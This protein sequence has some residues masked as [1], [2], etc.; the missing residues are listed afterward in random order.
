MSSVNLTIN[1]KPV[2]VEKG[3][4]ILEAAKS[5]N[6]KIPSLCHLNMN[7]VNMVNQCASC[8]VCMVSAG[9]GLVPACGTLVKEG[10]DVQTNTPGALKARKNVVELLLSDHPQDCLLCEK[11]GNCELQDIAA[12]L[13]IR[14]IRYKG[15][16]STAPTDHST[17]SIVKDHDKCILCRRCETMCNEVQTVGVLSGVN[18]GF[19]TEVGTF[20]NSDLCET[21]CTFCGQCIAV[22]PT[23]AL[24]EVNNIPTVWNALASK[25]KTVVVQVAPAVRVAIGEE[26]GLEAGEISTGK[27]VAALRA[28][29]FKYVFDTNYAADLTILEEASEFLHRLKE[30][31]NL[32]ILTSCCPA[33]INFVEKN[34]PDLLNLPSSCKS[35]QEMFGAIAKNYFAPKVANIEPKDLYV[36]SVMP[37]VAK[38]YEASRTEL[39]QEDVLDVDISITT[40]ELAKMFKEAGINLSDLED[41]SFDNPLGESTGAADIFGATGGVLEAALRTAYEWVTD[42]DL[43]DVNFTQVRGMEGIKEASINIDGTVINACIASSLGNAR[44]VMDEVAA[45]NS[46]YHII[47]IMACPGGCVAGGGQ[48]Y[49]KGDYDIVKKRAAGLYN[50]DSNKELRKSHKNPAIVALYDEFLGEPYGEAAHKYLHT[51][52]FDKSA[53]YTSC[54]ECSCAIEAEATA[55]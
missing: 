37:C 12:D 17:K 49:H 13:G 38:K 52:Y 41:E 18:R 51:H 34:Y 35:P 44:K 19:E 43:A 5:V 3:T 15:E 22:C 30:A 2:A 45:G 16:Q 14:N 1:G 33:W 7:E 11:S 53:I 23:G 36:V 47:E 20:F 10:M 42:T 39:G 24:T 40:R 28:L 31:H 21:E 29:G 9:R 25:D 46:K 50:I 48:P 54:E 32:P 26:F 6:V 55:E 8:R 4:T 27:M